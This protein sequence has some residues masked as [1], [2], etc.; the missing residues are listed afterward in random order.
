MQET[1]AVE[2]LG[3]GLDPPMQDAESMGHLVAL[4]DN[5]PL[6]I[7]QASAYIAEMGI[8]AATYPSL[9]PF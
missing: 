3:Q 5:L 2:L 7:R 8:S 6:A 1:E 9:L 4:L